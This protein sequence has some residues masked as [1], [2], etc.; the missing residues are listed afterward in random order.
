MGLV[1]HRIRCIQEQER[2]AWRSLPLV[3]IIGIA[4]LS[5][6]LFFSVSI[7]RNLSLRSSIGQQMS[8]QTSYK[9]ENIPVDAPAQKLI[10]PSVEQ[11]L[12]QPKVKAHRM[13]PLIQIHSM[14]EIALPEMEIEHEPSP[15]PTLALMDMPEPTPSKVTA[16]ARPKAAS[17]QRRQSKR[18]NK[19]RIASSSSSGIIK[20]ERISYRSAPEPPFP[21][22][23][24]ARQASGSVRVR[25][26]VS[27]DGSP[28]R[29][30]VLRSSGH[31]LLDET[32]RKWIMRKWLFNPAKEQ[33][34]AIAAV[35]TTS[36]NFVRG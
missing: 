33:G 17:A 36:I 9:E 2:I 8:M 31:E 20:S 28:T 6:G 13:A 4:S 12:S 10:Q 34:I 5:V 16:K 3:A 7:G 35:V 19:H 30:E 25:I 32:A 22:L 26:C 11:L 29:V 23:M 14:A 27:A 1:A 15:T 24:L 18:A 21:S